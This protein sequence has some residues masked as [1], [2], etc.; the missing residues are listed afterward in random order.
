MAI[1]III[2]ILF[3]VYLAAPLLVG[4]LLLLLQVL[5]VYIHYW[6]LAI[7]A[8]ICAFLLPW[9]VGIPALII[10]LAQ[11]NKAANQEL[12]NR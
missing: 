10:V 1:A 9:Y 2:L 5:P 12:G 3:M 11:G 7:P 6:Y 8:T 4:C